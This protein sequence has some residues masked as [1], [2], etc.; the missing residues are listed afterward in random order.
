MMSGSLLSAKYSASSSQLRFRAFA[1]KC[2]GQE[3]SSL[4]SEVIQAISKALQNQ[5]SL[6]ALPLLVLFSSFLSTFKIKNVYPSTLLLSCLCRLGAGVLKAKVILEDYSDGDEIFEALAASPAASTLLKLDFKRTKLS[7]RCSHLWTAFKSIET[8]KLDSPISREHFSCLLSVPS[9]NFCRLRFDSDL[10]SPVNALR[11]IIS[12]NLNIT[13]LYL[14]C[15]EIASAQDAEISSVLLENVEFA[16]H[17]VEFGLIDI[18]G[19]V[20]VDIS[21]LLQGVQPVFK[22]QTSA[23]RLFLTHSGI[24]GQGA[25][26]IALLTTVTLNSIITLFPALTKLILETE[27]LKSMDLSVLSSLTWLRLTAENME[28]PPTAWPRSL[29]YLDV[30]V[31]ATSL[32]F[33][34]DKLVAVVCSHSP[35]LRYLLIRAS[36]VLTKSSAMTAVSS[37]P[38]LRR[39][40]FFV[41]SAQSDLQISHPNLREMPQIGHFKVILGCM[42]RLLQ[43]SQALNFGELFPTVGQV[44]E[45]VSL[46]CHPISVSLALERGFAGLTELRLT[47]PSSADRRT[48]MKP[49]SFPEDTLKLSSIHKLSCNSCSSVAEFWKTYCKSNTKLR[50]LTLSFAALGGDPKDFPAPFQDL[51]FLELPMP[52]MTDLWLASVGGLFPGCPVA[53][54]RATGVNFPC[55]SEV[56]LEFV[57]ATPVSEISF[58][59]L[60]NLRRLS[61]VR[62]RRFSPE[63][64]FTDVSVANCQRLSVLILRDF[65]VSR[66]NLSH[67]QSIRVLTL[68]RNV[69]KISFVS[70]S[71][72]RP[73]IEKLV[74]FIGVQA[75]AVLSVVEATDGRVNETQPLQCLVANYIRDQL[76]KL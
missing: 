22:A 21:S 55:L 57:T 49:V 59:S 17:L 45:L 74:S 35:D 52:L 11:D 70:D 42:P 75:P 54:V 37:L 14:G 32:R 62:N 40:H 6:G 12:K 10:V 61:I 20:C 27:I 28:D 50:S 65:G 46:E 51:P 67:L 30:I 3:I 23:R 29:R 24:Q 39:L 1:E 60:A 71:D 36:C 19:N 47:G 73:E 25:P 43:V 7:D 41:E 72:P 18:H 53:P 15:A 38:R 44:P 64:G 76:T 26:E 13:H 34:A 8:I 16:A 69:F 9:P 66:L 68:E 2:L 56:Q 33:S 58:R 48:R 31:W 63:G 5:I 4:P